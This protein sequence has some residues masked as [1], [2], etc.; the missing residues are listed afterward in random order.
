[1]KFVFFIL[2][3][4]FPYAI[5]FGEDCLFKD[6]ESLLKNQN[7]IKGTLH[8]VARDNYTNY[9]GEARL[10]GVL[11]WRRSFIQYIDGWEFYELVFY[12]DKNPLFDE[13]MYFTLYRDDLAAKF[14]YPKSKLYSNDFA[15]EFHYPTQHISDKLKLSLGK[16]W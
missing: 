1:M 5:L 14:H 11:I 10:S 2:L 13:Y 16:D 4:W 15:A 8:K 6:L 12:P 7:T 3:I 9:I